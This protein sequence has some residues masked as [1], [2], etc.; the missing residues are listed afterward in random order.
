MTVPP[1][2]PSPLNI[3]DDAETVVL[4]EAAAHLDWD[5]NVPF[6]TYYSQGYTGGSY[7]AV[8]A[9]FDKAIGL[10]EA[11]TTEAPYRYTICEMAYLRRYLRDRPEKAAILAGDAYSITGGGITSAENL[12]THGEAFVRNYLLGRAFTHQALGATKS[13]GTLW[14]PDDFGHDSQLPIVVKAMGFDA[15]AFWRIPGDGAKVPA[16]SAAPSAPATLLRG[17][18]GVGV[19]FTWGAADGS[20][21]TAHWLYGSYCQGNNSTTGLGYG[22]PSLSS[23][24]L[25]AGLSSLAGAQ[26]ETPTN[27]GPFLSATRY[28]FVPIDCDFNT[29]YQNLA[30]A[31]QTWNRAQGWTSSGF[32]GSKPKTYLV[33]ASFQDFATLVATDVAA[34]KATLTPITSFL[35]NPYFSGCYASHPGLKQG[36]QA[37]TR[38][39]LAAESMAVVVGCLQSTT[40]AAQ[41]GLTFWKG[42]AELHDRRIHDAW[43]MLMPST[44]HDLLPGTAPDPVYRAEQRPRVDL[45]LAAAIEARGSVLRSL[46]QGVSATPKPGELAFVVWSSVATTRTALVEIELPPWLSIASARTSSESALAFQAAGGGRWLV[47]VAAPSLGYTTL[48][49]TTTPT[50]APPMPAPRGVPDGEQYRLDNGLVRAFVCGA[51]GALLSL[52]DL[53]A[54][55]DATKNLLAGAGNDIVYFYDEGGL[56]RFGMEVLDVSRGQPVVAAF[57]PMTPSAETTTLTVLEEGPLRTTVRAQTTF[58]LDRTDDEPSFTSGPSTI[59]REYSLH[60]GEK[61]LRMTTVGSAPSYTSV[62]ASFTGATESASLCHGTAVHHTTSSPRQYFTAEAY[63]ASKA[64]QMTFEPTHDFVQALAADGSF[65]L[66]FFHEA[67]HAWAIETPSSTSKTLLACLLR[68]TPLEANNAALGTDASTYALRYAITVPSGMASPVTGLPQRDA[69]SYQSELLA[70]A[71]PVDSAN[72]LPETLSLASTTGPEL[73]TALKRGTMDP[74]ALVLRVQQPAAP[75]SGGGLPSVRVTLAPGLVHRAGVTACTALELPQSDAPAVTTTGNTLS[76]TPTGALATV[77][78][79]GA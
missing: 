52:F 15:V 70:A 38:A 24:D 42:V 59:V 74:T 13:I 37:A 28:R 50:A 41:N 34:G 4:F 57:H 17:T 16:T 3:P 27:C 68:N 66:G 35:P 64:E 78:I 46:A 32:S 62:M 20:S 31:I 12:M 30:A 8:K 11:S 65:V 21:V 5:W 56:Y 47:H 25:Q 60:A 53:D 14:L 2:P 26:A 58:T 1:P 7:E 55:P 39:L 77:A 49:V 10:V 19:D 6:E 22:N 73:V 71:I 61:L 76:L 9:T 72:T 48:Y 44:H 43:E 29:P 40:T 36:H 75:S 33:M 23:A 67:T 63:A 69:R 54:D 51:T 45:A 79:P 18:S